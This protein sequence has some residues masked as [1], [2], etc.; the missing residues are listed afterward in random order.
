MFLL[1]IIQAISLVIDSMVFI[2]LLI[3]WKCVALV[4]S[5]TFLVIIRL[6]D[7]NEVSTSAWI[8]HLCIWLLCHVRTPWRRSPA[9]HIWLSKRAILVLINRTVYLFHM[10]C[11]RRGKRLLDK[12]AT[13]AF[14]NVEM[15]F[16]VNIKFIWVLGPT[17][18]IL[19]QLFQ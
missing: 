18:L 14:I 5:K 17:C 15:H 4:L 7:L 1:W 9:T 19:L 16:L 8:Q 10:I 13:M 12:N 3:S 2:L 11:W 6:S